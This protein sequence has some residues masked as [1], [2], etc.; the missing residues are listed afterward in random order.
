LGEQSLH[1]LPTFVSIPPTESTA[2]DPEFDNNGNGARAPSSTRKTC[3]ILLDYKVPLRDPSGDKYTN[4]N[5]GSCRHLLANTE[6]GV[7]GQLISL[8]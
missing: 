7:L 5:A 4:C 1:Y 6:T 8:K 2:P 3:Y